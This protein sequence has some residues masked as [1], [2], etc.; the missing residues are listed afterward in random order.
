LNIIDDFGR[1]APTPLFHFEIVDPRLSR[2][3]IAKKKPGSAS[4]SLAPASFFEEYFHDDLSE[5]APAAE[6]AFRT[7]KDLLEREFATSIDALPTKITDPREAAAYWRLGFLSDDDLPEVAVSLLSLGNFD[8]PSLR[9]LAGEAAG[10]PDLA[11]LFRRSLAELSVE[12][13]SDGPAA[14]DWLIRRM[15]QKIVDGTLDPY[16]GARLIWQIHVKEPSG[17]PLEAHPFIYAASEYES[18]PEDRQFFTDAILREAKDLLGS[19]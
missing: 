14:A 5:G 10:A 16:Q 19:D 18:R 6:A 3:W 4:I 17:S 7:A 1:L 8:S 13:F 9:R 11:K 15:A 12:E 2:Y